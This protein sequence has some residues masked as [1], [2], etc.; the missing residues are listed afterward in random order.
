MI[1]IHYA[2]GLLR[3]EFARRWWT[4][5]RYPV[6]YLT[7]IVILYLLFVGIFYGVSSNMESAVPGF[8]TTI[9]GLVLG[10]CMWFF[11]VAVFNQLRTLLEIEAATGTL[12][13]L[14]LAPA[15]FVTI[16]FIRSFAGFLYSLLS[17]AV[18]LVL[19]MA[20][21]HRWLNISPGPAI[22]VIT[23]AMIGVHGAALALGGI[24]LVF[25]RVGQLNTI[26]QF[27]FIF[28]S[29]P[30]IEKLPPLWQAVAYSFPLARGMTLLRG[31]V[32]DGWVLSDPEA[33]ANLASLVFNSACYLV[34]GTAAYL[35]CERIARD[36]GMLGH[37]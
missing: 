8:G 18:L 30:P 1:A 34:I 6:D 32:V 31:M 14:F 36:Q 13:Q 19:I 3:S 15:R 22:L 12:E 11:T 7:G 27:A 26:V 21:T 5:I 37:Y 28:L 4:V 16:L 35:L 23:L 10:T 17:V 9:D 25:K 24:S 2:V 20:T 33:L 29:F